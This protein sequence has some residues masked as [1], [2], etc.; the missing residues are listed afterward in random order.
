M[1]DIY[2]LLNDI[3][4]DENEFEEM[5]VSELEKAKVKNTLKKSINKKRKMQSWKKNVAVASILVGL[6]A[7]TFGL[8]FPAYAKN[9]PVIEDIFRFFDNGRTESSIDSNDVKDEEKG[10]YYNYKQFSNEINLTKESNGIKITVN[11]AVFDGKTVTLTYSIESEQDLGKHAGTSLPKIEGMNALGGTDRTTKIDTNKYVGI[12]TVSNLE[13][14]TLDI[15]NIKWNI[16][17]I[18]NPDN[19]TEIKGDW[20]F[21]FSLNAVDSTMQLSDSSSERNGVKV[22]IEKISVNP[23]SFI[24]YYDQIV[25]ENISNKWD[26][27]DVELE[28]KDDLGNVYSGE[29]NGGKGTDSYNMSFSKTFEKLDENATKLIVSPHITLRDYNSDNYSSVEVSKDGVEREITLPEK[30]GKGKEEFV[31]EDIVIELKK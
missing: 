29:G 19:H 12:L 8:T 22:N 3:N 24:V 1:K 4:I 17:S 25:S 26:G 28:I 9:I 16:D 10:L 21:D 23:M 18:Q 11:D 14:K 5:E 30:S 13:D 27:V 15:A 6:S 20:N 31:L 7:T 2:E